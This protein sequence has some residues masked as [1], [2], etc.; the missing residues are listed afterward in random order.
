MAADTR[1]VSPTNRCP[2][3]SSQ[4]HAFYLKYCMDLIPTANFSDPALVIWCAEPNS[5]S[6]FSSALRFKNLLMTILTFAN[7]ILHPP[8]CPHG[9][10]LALPTSGAQSNKGSPL[11]LTAKSEVYPSWHW[12]TLWPFLITKAELWPEFLLKEVKVFF[13]KMDY[14]IPHRRRC[15]E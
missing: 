15:R 4:K 10:Q 11:T 5:S 7:T 6:S 1:N 14:L 8:W 13:P 3:V 9:H 2:K 12:L